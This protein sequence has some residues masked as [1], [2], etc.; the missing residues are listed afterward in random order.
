MHKHTG[1]KLLLLR[2]FVFVPACYKHTGI[3]LLLWREFVFFWGKSVC[4][5]LSQSVNP[6]VLLVNIGLCHESE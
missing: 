1:I 6:R 3:K 5:T 2:E 4:T